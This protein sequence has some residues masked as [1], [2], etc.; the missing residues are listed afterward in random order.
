M[1]LCTKLVLC[2]F[3]NNIARQACSKLWK[4]IFYSVF[5]RL[6]H[7]PQVFRQVKECIVLQLHEMVR[8]LHMVACANVFF[9]FFFYGRDWQGRMLRFM[10]NDNFLNIFISL[11]SSPS[12][13]AV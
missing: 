10:K 12:F 7:F 9:F 8:V 3:W 2:C 5:S 4:K 1:C 6:D 11:A 13:W